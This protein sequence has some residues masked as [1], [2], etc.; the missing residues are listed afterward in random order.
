[1]SEHVPKFDISALVSKLK[2]AK[3]NALARRKERIE[4]NKCAALAKTKM[5]RQFK[6]ASKSVVTKVSKQ[7]CPEVQSCVE[8]SASSVQVQPICPTAKSKASTQQNIIKTVNSTAKY[9]TPCTTVVLSSQLC[10]D[11][12]SVRNA[13]TR[14]R[15]RKISCDTDMTVTPVAGL[16]AIRNKQKVPLKIRGVRKRKQITCNNSALERKRQG[17]RLRAKKYRDKIKNDADKKQKQTEKEHASYLRRIASGSLK[18]I[19]QLSDRDRRKQRKQWKINTASYRQTKKR[20]SQ[21]ETVSAPQAC[22][23]E[24]SPL[25]ASS[26]RQVTGRNKVRK[27]RA[28]CYR[29]L[30]E[31]QKELIKSRRLASMYKKRNQRLRA[32]I[33]VPGVSPSPNTKVRRLAGNRKIDPVVRKTLLFAE[34]LVSQLKTRHKQVK[35]D[36]QKQLFAKAIAGNILRKYRL[37]YHARQFLSSK[38][39]RSNLNKSN[40]IAYERKRK[41]NGLSKLYQNAVVTFLEQDCNSRVYPGKKDCITRNKEKKQKRMLCNTLQNLHQMFL[42]ETGNRISY[43]LFCRLRPFWVTIPKANERET[44]LCSKHD[45]LQFI[46]DR[47]HQKKVVN[48]TRADDMCKVVCCDA[49]AKWCMYNECNVCKDRKVVANLSADLNET[50]TYNKWVTRNETRTARVKDITV[51]VTVKD[52]IESTV[53]DLMDRL[54]SDLPQFCKHVYN[55]HHQ[56]LSMK[57]TKENL[58]ENAGVIHIDFS[59]N[60]CCKYAHEVQSVHFGASKQQVTLH[61]GIFYHRMI[62]TNDIHCIS[63][64][65][66]SDNTRHDP[67]AIWA[68]LTPVF[69]MIAEEFPQIET[70]HFVSDGPTSQYRNRK[71][72]YLFSQLKPLFVKQNKPHGISQK[73]AMEKAEQ[74]PSEARLSELLIA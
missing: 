50:V 27:D 65:S 11:Y 32:S 55:I 52:Q 45:N 49:K 22:E 14:Q 63:F 40:L 7:S 10:E 48:Q 12:S 57:N 31:S 4:A 61:T 67:S 21:D 58:A 74:M 18:N 38:R 62:S 41:V 42:S 29:R 51:K 60:Y 5:N 70:L 25:V 13:S 24:L 43:S 36:S 33:G 47:L 46:I 44:C 69:K 15:K 73:A 20:R 72:I 3:E 35:S 28:A 6:A 26:S 2:A 30:A 23:P 56:Y 37:L 59:E 16:Q 39:Y 64:C 34:V 68:H 8:A 71:S 66:I 53:K 54:N 19:T 9:T 1:M 17:D